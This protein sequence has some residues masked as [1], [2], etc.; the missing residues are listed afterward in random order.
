MPVFE[1]QGPDGATYEIDAPD[2]NAAFN[3]FKAVGSKPAAQANA[4]GLEPRVQDYIA[5]AKARV[6]GG[7][8][9]QPPN[10][11][12]P[13]APVHSEFDPARVP[14]QTP[15]AD[16]AIAF[17]MGALNGIPIVGPSFENVTLDMAGGLGSLLSGQ[18]FNS[19]RQE[20][21]DKSAQVQQQNDVASTLG[22]ATGTIGP[23]L[24]LGA[25][26]VGAKALGLTGDSILG[27]MATGGL[28][29]AAIGGA[30]TAA[31]G[32]SPADIGKSAAIN[33]GLALAI[34][35]IGSLF[36]GVGQIAERMNIPSLLN[37]GSAAIKRVGRAMAA[38]RNNLGAPIMGP[39]DELSAALNGQPILN[40]DR[41]GES[42]RALMRSAANNDPEARA[43]I[44]RTVADRFAG[45]GPRAVG[46]VDRLL[47]GSA[48]DL[49]LQ[50]TLKT[51]ARKANIPAYRKAY[52]DGAAGIIT[53]ELERLAGSPAVADA[54]RAAAKSGQNRSISEGFGAFNPK[55]TFTPD[56]RVTFR[57]NGGVAAYPDLQ[58]WDYTKRELDDMASAA[59]RAGRNGEAGTL[60]NLASTLRGELDKAVPSYAQ[61]RQGA[62]AFFGAEDALDAG[63]K[64]VSQN[65]TLPDTQQALSKMTPAERDAFATGF[66]S[67][68][69]NAINSMPDRANVIDRIYGS[70]ESRQKIELAL[71]P[72]KARQFEAFTRVE[73]IM[74]KL[75]GSMG[76][77]T[78][79]R[80]LKELG[81]ATAAG[82]GAG[83]VTGDWKTG[84]TTGLLVRGARAYGAK[85]DESMAKGI[86][87]L[88]LSNDPQRIKIAIAVAS[89]SPKGLET[90]SAMQR[91]LASTAQG[92][93]LA[94][95]RTPSQP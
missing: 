81:M 8:P 70:P 22:A 53:P 6:E 44:D 63:R 3:A 14:S 17:S 66:A 21:A 40:V 18:P 46:F 73:N 90:V 25:T 59:R 72:N 9:I 30:D 68:L 36:N 34:P 67:E 52:Q 13:G 84:L 89:R 88:L 76:N 7:A 39:Q 57:N 28:T 29:N 75:R 77:S 64:F 20:M 31:R 93:A 55:V 10:S 69:K 95:S 24:G 65:R 12:A 16:N 26:Q 78:T 32:G 71:G 85:V 38:D 15:G 45:Q 58:L 86:A 47:G 1:L 33:G 54:M 2:E 49:A 82:T 94:G 19:V 61:A 27:R 62:A 60:E 42:A 5:R 83:Y 87:S 56:G 43:V 4:G 41:G 79:A 91:F 35:G 23:M 92:A 80:Q 51:A 50:N 74:D 48:D 37:P 11:L